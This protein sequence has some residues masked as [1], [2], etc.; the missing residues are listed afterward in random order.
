MTSSQYVWFSDHQGYVLKENGAPCI[1]ET[2]EW[3]WDENDPTRDR[4]SFDAN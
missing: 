3:K 4:R 1:N 2:C